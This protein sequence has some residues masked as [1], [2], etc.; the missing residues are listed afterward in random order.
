MGSIPVNELGRWFERE[1]GRLVLYV[2]QWL[3]QAT[4]E[5]VVQDVFVRLMLQRRNPDNVK[6]WLYRATRNAALNQVRTG[7]RR[8]QREEHFV[9]TAPS[10]FEPQ[11]AT[12]IDIGHAEK[13]LRELAE[14][15]R[16]IV[17]LRIWGDL[18]LDEIAAV[19]DI[20]ISSVF[21][22]YRHGLDCLRKRMGVLCQTKID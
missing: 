14:D 19:M 11:G 8:Q 6:A 5:D 3:D 16:E 4:A 12:A 9:S 20:S 7:N 2:R 17:M 10:W 13:A 15:E 1:A 18:T 21:R 22:K